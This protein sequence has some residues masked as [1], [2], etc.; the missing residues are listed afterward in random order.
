MYVSQ[1]GKLDVSPRSEGINI[2]T[3]FYTFVISCIVFE[4]IIVVALNKGLYFSPLFLL[5]LLR[6]ESI[7]H[8][9]L[10]VFLRVRLWTRKGM[11]T[12]HPLI[13]D[14]ST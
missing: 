14:L 12:F 2:H 10:H 7:P 4:I 9:T 3:F 11:R 6:F 1:S 8:K 5:F 13:G